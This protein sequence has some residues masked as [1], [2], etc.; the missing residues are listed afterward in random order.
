MGHSESIS[1]NFRHKVIIDEL[2]II[3]KDEVVEE[4]K[5]GRRTEKEGVGRKG[6]SCPIS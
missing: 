1:G 6:K 4:A 5:G 2:A 3:C